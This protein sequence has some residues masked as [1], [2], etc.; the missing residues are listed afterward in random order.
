MTILA[1]MHDDDLRDLIGRMIERS[2][3]EGVLV[4][5][6]AEALDRAIA[7]QVDVL[8]IEVSPS[9]DGRAVVETLRGR[10]AGLRVVYVS[11]WFDHPDF[12]GLEGGSIL[13]E[14]FSRVELMDAIEAVVDAPGAIR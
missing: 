11:G 3:H 8:L 13:K 9:M 4:A 6:E 14:P 12:I 1:V 10:T 7:T 5:D 2:D